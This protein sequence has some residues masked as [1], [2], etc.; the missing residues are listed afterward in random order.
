MPKIT[1]QFTIQ[2]SVPV[3]PFLHN[4]FYG[5]KLCMSHL[6]PASGRK[7]KGDTLK[8]GQLTFSYDRPGD[9]SLRP[10]FRANSAY[11]I[12]YGV[13]MQQ[14]SFQA[15]RVLTHFPLRDLETEHCYVWEV[16]HKST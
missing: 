14:C 9:L 10:F 13:R 16:E 5:G 3:L 4:K 7:T 8:G 2:E 15:L 1:L 6:S 11:I 12:K